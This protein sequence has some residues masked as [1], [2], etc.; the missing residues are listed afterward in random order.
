MKSGLC[1]VCEVAGYAVPQQVRQGSGLQM[2]Y[3][4]CEGIQSRAWNKGEKN[5]GANIYM[6]KQ[7][8][9]HLKAAVCQS[10]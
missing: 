7:S 6:H 9:I 4:Q 8:K 2:Y 3:V 10:N 5:W 1:E